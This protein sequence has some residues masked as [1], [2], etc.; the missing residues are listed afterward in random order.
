[1]SREPDATTEALSAHSR[2]DPLAAE[3]LLPLVYEKLRAVAGSYMKGER[4]DHTLQPTALVHEAYLRLIDVARMDWKGKTHFFAMAATEMRRVLVDHA[5]ARSARKRS[6]GKRV[7]L[8]ESA[9]LVEGQPV[10]LIDLSD[11]LDRLA[12]LSARQCKVAELRFFGG[13]NVPET[14]F[15]LGVSER[16]VKD[17]WK[18]ARVWLLRELEG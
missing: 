18:F 8:H 16:T 3:E 6:G 7:T 13:L 9:G 2:G 5:R 15:A 4:S 12:K 17:D 1:M 14:A 10:D 11:A